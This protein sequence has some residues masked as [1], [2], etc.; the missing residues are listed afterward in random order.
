M[1]RSAHMYVHGGGATNTGLFTSNWIDKL[2]EFGDL[3]WDLASRRRR[4]GD[5][6]MD[7]YLASWLFII[8]S[9]N[10][11]YLPVVVI[12]SPRPINS[13]LTMLPLIVGKYDSI[14]AKE[15][16]AQWQLRRCFSS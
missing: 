9:K 5:C 10:D 4:R 16:S 6:F 15:R 8:G 1:D 11:R 7:R 14:E 13:P 12:P 2:V 3:L